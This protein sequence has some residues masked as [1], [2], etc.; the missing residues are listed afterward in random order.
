IG[1][2]AWVIQALMLVVGLGFIAALV[3]AWAYEMTPDGI[4]KESEVD[5]SVS[6]APQTGQKLDRIV[7]GFLVIAVLVLLYRQSGDSPET[8]SDPVSDSE[9]SAAVNAET[10]ILDPTPVDRKSIAVLPFVNMSSD[11]E[12]EYFS[13]GITEEILNRLAKIPDLQVAARTSVFSFKGQNLDVRE[14]ANMLG[15]STMLEGSVRRDGEM[16][17]ITAQLIR[18][19]DGFHL[20]SESYDREIDS[21]FAVQDE[22]S[23]QIAEALQVSL[24]ISG[25]AA[26]TNTTDPEVYDLYLRGR[27]LHRQRGAENLLKALTLFKSALEID[28]EFAPAWAGLSHSLNVVTS[29]ASQDEI[30]ELGDVDNQSLQAAQKALEL[31]PNLASA[32][33]A[34]A[35]NHLARFQWSEAETYYDQALAQDPESTD[36]ME[37]YGHFLLYSWR[38]EEARQVAD[39]MISL[40]P[41]VPVFRFMAMRVY[42]T[43]SN[44]QR[45]GEHV[46]AASAISDELFN[47]QRQKLLY[48]LSIEDFE[49]ARE[50]A[51]L[52]N[53]KD[54]TTPEAMQSMVDWVANPST[55]PTAVQMQ[56]LAFFQ[57]GYLVAGQYSMWLDEVLNTQDDSWENVLVFL[58]YLSSYAEEEQFMRL[59]A[60]PRS[61][62]WLQRSGLPVYWRESGWPPRCRP[63]GADDFVCE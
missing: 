60:D 43:L 34:M 39:R 14:V 9:Y 13:D 4:K 19:S 1:A 54:W 12:Q 45:W 28:P 16:V 61:K 38:T 63:L 48:L 46:E 53:L 18:A 56:A 7:I 55:E 32:L 11:P 3:I 44:I 52:M 50:F 36:I 5:R 21:I 29:Y 6:I 25:G 58:S 27:A 20:W 35:N 23:Q 24:G 30:S 33:H 31:D 17:R 57:V 22:I 49:S 26:N 51:A 40:D 59:H 15:V 47:V 42:H 10:Q 2:P 41:Y 62:A 37:D 8:G